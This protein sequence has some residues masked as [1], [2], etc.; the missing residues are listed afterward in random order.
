M[1]APEEATTSN[2]WPSKREMA[3]RRY[4]HNIEE[5][6]RK[7]RDYYQRNK[8]LIKAHSQ[9]WRERNPDKVRNAMN[10]Y[11]KA[12]PEKI[13]AIAKRHYVA[14]RDERLEAM[15]EYSKRFLGPG[16]MIRRAGFSALVDEVIDYAGGVCQGCG[17]ERS[18]G[19]V[20]SLCVHH[21]DGDPKNHVLENLKLLCRQCHVNTH[22][23]MRVGE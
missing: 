4:H 16:H 11:A 10:A 19:V 18:G 20:G 23:E 15:R 17:A 3:R 8:G 6:R 22:V 21:L 2:E 9:A 5:T 13:R 7:R 1:S 14:H 12:N